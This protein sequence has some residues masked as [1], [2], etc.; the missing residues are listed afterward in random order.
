MCVVSRHSTT[1][2]TVIKTERGFF[3]MK[4]EVFDLLKK[5]SRVFNARGLTYVLSEK[6]IR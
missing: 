5:L 6:I 4:F 2:K 3:W 1:E